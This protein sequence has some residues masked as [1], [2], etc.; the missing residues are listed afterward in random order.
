MMADGD[1]LASTAIEIEGIELASP[2]TD[3]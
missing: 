2:I 3:H 1:D